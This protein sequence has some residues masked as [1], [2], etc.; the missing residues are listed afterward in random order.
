MFCVCVCYK[1]YHAVDMILFLCL[2]LT[3]IFLRPIHLAMYAFSLTLHNS[4]FHVYRSM[5]GLKF[6]SC[7]PSHGSF[8]FK[9]YIFCFLCI[10]HF[11]SCSKFSRV[12]FKLW[13]PSF[14][15]E[16][17]LSW[18]PSFS[19]PQLSWLSFGYL[20]GIFLLGSSVS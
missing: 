4:I 13:K 3:M 7:L 10:S 1:L 17:S 12:V 19:C 9:T 2:S 11:W 5:L 8:Q 14:F 6:L 18:E 16:F 20:S 15:P